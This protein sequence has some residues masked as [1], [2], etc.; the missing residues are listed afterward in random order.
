MLH[1]EGALIVEGKY[2]KI[3]L[4]NLVDCPMIVT[5]G[6]SV[7]KDPAT[8]ALIKWY[9]SHGGITILTDSDSAGFKIRGYIK[10]IVSE[11][12]VRNVYIP[13]I[14]GKERRKLAPSAEGKLGVEGVD[15]KIL[16]AA[17]EK[18]GIIG[19]P[20]QSSK[21]IE[22]IDLF[23]DGFFG[24]KDSSAKRS[25]LLKRLDLPEKLSTSGLIDVLNTALTYEEYK[26]LANELNMNN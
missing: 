3:H 7:F 2:D 24:G 4:T 14:F 10:G 1:I 21:R 8:K 18:A 13:D 9:A 15:L 11:G 23:E 19:K 12:T 25:L 5:N 22:R 6:F 17:F 20:K 26:S 16:E